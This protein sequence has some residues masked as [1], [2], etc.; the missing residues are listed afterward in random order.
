MAR[1]VEAQFDGIDLKI[2]LGELGGDGDG[3]R[4]A[5]GIT[6]VVAGALVEVDQRRS[7]ALIDVLSFGVPASGYINGAV[8]FA[9]RRALADAPSG[10]ELLNRRVEGVEAL[11]G[12][13][14]DGLD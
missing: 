9:L 10:L 12:A 2:L 5:G 8:G 7:Y 3:V 14:A 6:G 1:E 13:E 11:A 4:H